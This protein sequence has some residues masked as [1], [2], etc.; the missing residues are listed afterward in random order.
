MGA[1]SLLED[2]VERRN[3]SDFL[4][5]QLRR[6]SREAIRTMQQFQ[7]YQTCPHCSALL[8]SRKVSRHLRK[9]HNPS[10]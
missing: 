9:V 3:D 6:R 10:I 1:V 4:T 5:R 8:N 7:S 2:I